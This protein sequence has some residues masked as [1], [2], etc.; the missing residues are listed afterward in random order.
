VLSLLPEST[1]VGSVCFR[2]ALVIFTLHLGVEGCRWQ[3]APAYLVTAILFVASAWP[4]F[5][6]LGIWPGGAL[7]VFLL[8]AAGMGIIMPVFDFPAP[9]GP[10][11]IGSLTQH[12]V[13]KARSENP[14]WRH[15][16][17]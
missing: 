11:K 12:L 16:P 7:F 6:K 15:R 1:H 13:D 4:Q 17:A 14:G 3:M 5:L 2:C 10:Y 8:G 9:T